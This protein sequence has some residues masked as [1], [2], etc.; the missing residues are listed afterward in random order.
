MFVIDNQ[1]RKA[2]YEQIVEQAERLVLMDLLVADQPM[3]SVRSLS[4][5]LSVNPNTIQKAYAELD[6]RG[7]IY[8]SPG[9]GSFVSSKAKDALAKERLNGLSVIEQHARECALAGIEKSLVY[10]AVDKGYR[11]IGGTDDSGE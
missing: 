2:V 4:M 1:S 9:K 11:R 7:I 3:P 6:R 5:E 10:E 8:I